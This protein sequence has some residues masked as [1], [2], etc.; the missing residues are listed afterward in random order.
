VVNNCKHKNSDE[1]LTDSNMILNVID[2]YYAA[3]ISACA[4]LQLRVQMKDFFDGDHCLI[5]SRIAVVKQEE[6]GHFPLP[7]LVH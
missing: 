1:D 7:L 6:G 2:L 5:N 4:T 3:R